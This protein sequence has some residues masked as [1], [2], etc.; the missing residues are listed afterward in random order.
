MKQIRLEALKLAVQ[1]GAEGGNIL[2]IAA[3]YTDF[4]TNGPKVVEIKQEASEAKINTPQ[5]TVV[6]GN[7]QQRQTRK[8]RR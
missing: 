6:E 8:G 1:A 7:R 4:I 5:E 3:E 2:D